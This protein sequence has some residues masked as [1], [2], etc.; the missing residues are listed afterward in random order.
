MFR[1]QASQEVTRSSLAL[2]EHEHLVYA[3][4]QHDEQ[5]AETIMRHHIVRARKNIETRLLPMKS[6]NR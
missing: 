2:S 3:I 1:Y 6:G 5:L 4:E